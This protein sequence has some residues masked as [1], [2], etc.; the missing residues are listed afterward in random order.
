[1]AYSIRRPIFKWAYLSNCWELSAGFDGSS[2]SGLAA[3]VHSTRVC[4]CRHCASRSRRRLTTNFRRSP[5]HS[6]RLFHLEPFSW[7][8]GVLHLG[9]MN[10]LTRL[11]ERIGRRS[12][13]GTR[14]PVGEPPAKLRTRQPTH[15]NGFGASCGRRWVA[16]E[17]GRT[18]TSP[19]PRQSRAATSCNLRA[20]AVPHLLP[21]PSFT[22]CNK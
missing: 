4:V 13:H 6:E 17:D 7:P 16:R 12:F 22:S 15:A 8:L 11:C 20:L 19:W 2:S 18:A 14:A 5:I 3:L 1:M 10:H 9:S 21:P